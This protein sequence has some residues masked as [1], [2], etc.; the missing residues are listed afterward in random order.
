MGLFLVLEWFETCLYPE[1]KGKSPSK[2]YSTLR[3]G[4]RRRRAIS[5]VVAVEQPP[6]SSKA[7]K[8][9]RN[10]DFS[11]KGQDIE[12]HTENILNQPYSD[13]E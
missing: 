3:S 4:R 5:P 8:V 12:T 13:F 2:K 1:E 9:R 7:K 11:E 6:S 10:L